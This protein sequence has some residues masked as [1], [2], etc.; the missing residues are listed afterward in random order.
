MAD[1]DDEA[2]AAPVAVEEDMVPPTADMPEI[3]LFG[4]WSV[5]DF[6]FDI[7]PCCI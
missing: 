2:A 1:W 6:L 7:L 5:E 3:H 4:K